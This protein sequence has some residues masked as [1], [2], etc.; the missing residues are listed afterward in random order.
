MKKK[1]IC[2][3]GKGLGQKGVTLVELLL[4]VA[5]LSVSL[6]VIYRPLLASMSVLHY[7]TEREEANRFLSKKLWALQERFY[8]A[9]AE[10]GPVMTGAFTGKKKTYFYQI[11]SNPLTEDNRLYQLDARVSW[12]HSGQRKNLNRIIYAYLPYGIIEK[13]N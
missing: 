10:L 13:K 7:S 1:K 5:I 12:S 9:Q 2:R 6:I 4:C 11:S 3:N 8:A